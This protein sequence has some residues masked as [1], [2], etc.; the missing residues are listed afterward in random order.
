MDVTLMKTARRAKSAV[1]KAVTV[2]RSMPP[3]VRQDSGKIH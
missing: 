3:N 1:A 2:D